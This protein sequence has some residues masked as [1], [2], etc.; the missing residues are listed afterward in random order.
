MQLMES[1]IGTVGV[2][3][4]SNKET[5]YNTVAALTEAAES[6]E[7]PAVI[8]IQC[9]VAEHTYKQILEMLDDLETDP[10]LRR[11]EC[12]VYLSLKHKGRGSKFNILG[13]D[14]WKAILAKTKASRLPRFGVDVC[15][16]KKLL[17]FYSEDPE[18]NR[19]AQPCDA[20]YYNVCINV[21][22]EAF[23]CSFLEGSE[24][25]ETGES[26]VDKEFND[27]WLGT[28]FKTHREKLLH[29]NK[30][31]CDRSCILWEI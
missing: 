24:G 16:T 5:C 31:E 2:S 30:P 28:R 3:L 6:L 12:V 14:G 15:S 26:L 20:G 10:R 18:L 1:G 7:Y 23:P 4:N 8:Q 22:G 17:V 27:V 25:W 29:V 9:V 13:H 11:V 21:K 19:V